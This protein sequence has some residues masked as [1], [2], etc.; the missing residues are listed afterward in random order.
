[1][2]PRVGIKELNDNKIKHTLSMAVFDDCLV[3]FIF[4]NCAYKHLNFLPIPK[5]KTRF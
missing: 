3:F 5:T 2:E 4:E 1:M